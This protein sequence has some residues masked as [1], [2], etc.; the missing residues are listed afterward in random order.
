M[1]ITKKK[2]V[3]YTFTLLFIISYVH[4]QS[5]SA[6][7]PGFDN[8]EVCK[9]FKF[10]PCE[11]GGDRGCTVF[12]T[13]KLFTRGECRDE[14][15]W[16]CPSFDIGESCQGFKFNPC[17]RGGDRG[18]TVFCKRKLVTRGECRDEGCWCCPGQV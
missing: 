7:S 11:R 6:S 4:C 18:C 16:C 10:N 3:V 14:G 2:L 13:R 15:C 17:E 8:G 12:C 5:T 1:A 9:Q